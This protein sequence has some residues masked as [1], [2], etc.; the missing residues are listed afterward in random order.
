[1]LQYDTVEQAQMRLQ[2]SIIT[3]KDRAVLV[4]AAQPNAAGGID[5]YLDTYPVHTAG[6][7]KS[8]KS[9]R[10]H[11]DQTD[12][13]LNYRLFRLGYVNDEATRSAHYLSR[14][15]RRQQVQGI[16]PGTLLG[17]PQRDATFIYRAGFEDMLFDRYP[18]PKEAVQRL[19]HADEPWVKVGISRDFAVGV[20]ADFKKLQKLF[21]RDIAVGVTMGESAFS[22]ADD[23][24]FLAEVTKE[25]NIPFTLE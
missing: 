4:H 12:P 6:G 11:V 25:H 3:Y 10:L 18:T 14:A 2:G 8:K 13:N 20:D 21:Y 16:A 23:Y 1:M 7:N 17:V 22:L 24:K 15:G 5:L 9:E 19:N